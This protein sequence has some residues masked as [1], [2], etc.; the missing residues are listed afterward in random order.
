MAHLHHLAAEFRTWYDLET[1]DGASIHLFHFILP[2]RNPSL[3]RLPSRIEI[4]II[5]TQAPGRSARR[6]YALRICASSMLVFDLKSTLFLTARWLRK[7]FQGSY[8]FVLDAMDVHRN[9]WK[10]II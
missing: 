8:P 10:I 9:I 4:P 6:S 7:R 2:P 5:I 3:Y 1:R